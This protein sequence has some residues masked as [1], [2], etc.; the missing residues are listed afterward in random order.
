[1]RTLL[2]LAALAQASVAAPAADEVLY[3]VSKSTAIQAEPH[4]GARRIGRLHR[5][6]VV[7]GREAVRGWLRLDPSAAV[8]GA[9]GWIRIARENIVAGTGEALRSRLFRIQQTKWPTRVKVDVARGVI[10]RGYTAE[11]VQLALGDPV[12]KDLR[13][14]NGDVTESWTY[15]DCVVVF[16]HSAVAGVELP[17]KAGSYER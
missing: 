8:S 6:D 10:R 13:H 9:G 1:M 17:A 4:D 12:R 16:S 14:R 7:S 15:A 2:L 5:F 3:L 11:Q